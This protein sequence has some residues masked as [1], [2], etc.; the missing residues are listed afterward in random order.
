MGEPTSYGPQRRLCFRH[1]ENEFRL[2]LVE[3]KA[4]SAIAHRVPPIL[5]G[6]AGAEE[7]HVV[8]GPLTGRCRGL[9][10]GA[11]SGSCRVNAIVCAQL[12]NAE[13]EKRIAAD[14]TL[15]DTYL[16]GIPMGRLGDSN[17]IKGVGFFS[18]PPQRGSPAR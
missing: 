1:S 13:L 5:V 15:G 10:R 4:R 12:L 9:R 16:R 3:Y 2:E 7:V 17:D 6:D 18:P 8:E 11:S 14:P